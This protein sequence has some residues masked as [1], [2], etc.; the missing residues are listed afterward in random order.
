MIQQTRFVTYLRVSTQRQGQSGLGLEAQRK[1]VQDYAATAGGEVLAEYVEVESGKRN[2]RPK[3]AQAMQR[4]RLTGSILLIA[5]LDRLSRDAHFLIGL[6]KAGVEFVAADMP[7]ANRLTVGIMALVAQQEREAISAR[8]KAALAAAK[9]R[10]VVLGGYRGGPAVNQAEGVKAA[11]AAR[12]KAAR[13]FAEDVGPLVQELASGGLSLRQ[14]AARLTEQ[15]IRTARGGT[16]W[17]AAGVSR[18]LAVS[19]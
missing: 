6:E 19:A 5:K 17:T 10:G 12:R 2:D 9:A 13:G 15:G 8:T 18:V 1:A 3:L 14:V 4:C 7:H 16:V 11:S